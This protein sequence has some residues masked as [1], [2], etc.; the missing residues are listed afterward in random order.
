MTLLDGMKTCA[1]IITAKPNETII[2][3]MSREEVV[4]ST[5]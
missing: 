3:T 4:K 2:G 1:I 5:R